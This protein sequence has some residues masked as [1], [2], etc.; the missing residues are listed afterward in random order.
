MSEDAEAIF[1]ESGG[2]VQGASDCSGCTG[3]CA[4]YVTAPIGP[5]DA[6][7]IW[8]VVNE[9]HAPFYPAQSTF[10]SSSTYFVGLDKNHTPPPATTDLVGAG[11]DQDTQGPPPLLFSH[12]FNREGRSYHEFNAPDGVTAG[13]LR[14]KVFGWAVA[15]VAPSIPMYWEVLPGTWDVDAT[16]GSGATPRLVDPLHD[17]HWDDVG[18]PVALGSVTPTG[19]AATSVADFDDID[20]VIPVVGGKLR[21]AFACGASQTTLDG[22]VYGGGADITTPRVPDPTAHGTSENALMFVETIPAPG[23]LSL[24][25]QPTK[26]YSIEWLPITGQAVI[27]EA[28]ATGDGTTTAFNTSFPYAP[29]SLKVNIDIG[30]LTGTVTE[31][32][33]T[34]GAFT[35]TPAP[36]DTE[37][38]TA[39]YQG[40]S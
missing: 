7:R 31:T 21:F 6:L 20:V 8:E 22:H 24:L 1:G 37:A 4:P 14:T 15:S 16:T 12:W 2:Y 25:S 27:G 3:C 35:I 19:G 40:Q 33:P 38:I 11:I 9:T 17:P 36:Y 30:R 34:T 23:T 5:A 32:D 10:F 18:S 39:D 28:V 13:R 29:S 26:S